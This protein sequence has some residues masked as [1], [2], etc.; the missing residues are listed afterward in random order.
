VIELLAEDEFG[1]FEVA[2]TL[3]NS[4]LDGDANLRGY[5]SVPTKFAAVIK[6]QYKNITDT[7]FPT[8]PDKLLT[9]LFE[10]T[11]DKSLFSQYVLITGDESWT[12]FGGVVK[13]LWDETTDVSGNFARCTIVNE[14]TFFT[15][16]L[17]VSAKLSRFKL[18]QRRTRYYSVGAPKRYIIYGTN[19]IPS[20]DGDM[21]GWTELRDCVAT[22][23][24]GT[25]Y[26]AGNQSLS[27]ED[28]EAVLNGDEFSLGGTPEVRYIRI[29]FLENFAP[30]GYIIFSE[31]SFWGEIQ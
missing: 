7:I 20:E 12:T 31:L 30:S 5:P 16:D 13:E 1:K 18:H 21:S 3:Y 14:R 6:D 23:P 29:E 11:L 24:S 26:G 8:T 2:Q 10:S 22:S 17:G 27:S 25:I 28:L 4:I 9:P 19:E 15:M